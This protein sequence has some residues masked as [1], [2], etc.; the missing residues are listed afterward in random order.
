MFA[1][2]VQIIAACPKAPCCVMGRPALSHDRCAKPPL[3]SL[4]SC[5]LATSDDVCCRGRRLVDAPAGHRGPDSA[6]GGSSRCRGCLRSARGGG[7]TAR[8]LVP[9]AFG[10][11]SPCPLAAHAQARDH[12]FDPAVLRGAALPAP[13][14]ASAVIG[15]GAAPRVSSTLSRRSSNRPVSCSSPVTIA[16]ST[17]TPAPCAAG[18]AGRRG[19]LEDGAR[20]ASG[21]VPQSVLHLPVVRVLRS[22]PLA[23]STAPRGREISA[24]P[25]TPARIRR[26][27]TGAVSAGTRP[28]AWHLPP[29]AGTEG[30]K[31][32]FAPPLPCPHEQ[33]V[34]RQ[35]VVK[36]ASDDPAD[37]ESDLSLPHQS[38]PARSGRPSSAPSGAPVPQAAA[39]PESCP[40]SP[41]A[42]F[43][44]RAGYASPAMWLPP[45]R[46]QDGRPACRTRQRSKGNLAPGAFAGKYPLMPR[47]SARFS[48]IIMHKLQY[49]T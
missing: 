15:S 39:P 34:V 48:L 14:A 27:S 26:A 4:A 35:R 10:R 13:Q 7:G 38:H 30:A 46:T 23:S 11:A 45:A 2:R 21:S 44:P 1:G 22:A 9:E 25:L 43:R 8:A 29:N 31:H 17:T 36:P 41:P 24:S 16:P 28:A 40:I 47:P 37:R 49:L 32:R 20:V 33:G 12:G 3:H 5:A 6:P 18:K 42:G 19:A